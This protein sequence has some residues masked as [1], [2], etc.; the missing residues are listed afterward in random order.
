MNKRMKTITAP[1]LAALALAGCGPAEP[2]SVA[3]DTEKENPAP[4]PQA[5]K[6]DIPGGFASS[7]KCVSVL[8]NAMRCHYDDYTKRWPQL[9]G[10]TLATRD[11]AAPGGATLVRY[12]VPDGMEMKDLRDFVKGV[13]KKRLLVALGCGSRAVEIAKALKGSKAAVYAYVLDSAAD[14][15]A[16]READSETPVAVPVEESGATLALPNV[17]Y[18]ADAGLANTNALRKLQFKHGARIYVPSFGEPAGKLAD[19]FL[20]YGWD[21]TYESASITNSPD[22]AALEKRLNDRRIVGYAAG[23]I[24]YPAWLADGRRY[25]GTGIGYWGDEVPKIEAASALGANVVRIGFYSVK[26]HWK[27]T[28]AMTEERFAEFDAAFEERLAEIERDLDRVRELGIKAV[29]AGPQFPNP[30]EDAEL[31]A[32]TLRKWRVIARRFKGRTE[33]Y[34]YDIANELDDREKPPTRI[35]LRD[36]MTLAAAAIREEDSDVTLVVQ[37]IASPGGFES[38]NAFGFETATPLPFDNVVYSPH[39]YQPMAFTHQGIHKKAGEYEHVEYPGVFTVGGKTKTANK[40]YIRER[41][42]GVREFQLKY[43]ARIWVGE[44]SAAAWTKGGA[45]WLK[46]ASDLF[47]EYGWDY[48]Y[49]SFRESDIWSLERE[50]PE[51]ASLKPA[52]GE[53]DRMKVLKEKWALNAKER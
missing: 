14:V 20:K 35:R 17:F 34:G 48:C 8:G 22:A 28:G 39:I 18:T 46:D 4:A 40:D 44:F 10:V 53:T 43:G 12:V 45:E 24:R 5:I 23:T 21:W 15:A 29:V 13:E 36:F 31:T 41:L 50:G 25:R 2:T 7:R 32:Y 6:R 33:I 30:L 52:E 38:P 47:E 1:A 49:H 26:M 51:E 9:K 42:R 3:V 16:V 11:D 27:R 37:N 19:D